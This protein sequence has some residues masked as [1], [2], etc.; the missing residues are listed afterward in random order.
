MRQMSDKVR[1]GIIGFGGMGEAHA[2]YI[3]KDGVPH[4]VLTAVCDPLPG[5]LARARELFGDSV[6]GFAKAEDLFAA[7]LVDG[8]LIA[9]PHYV[10]PDLAIQAFSHGMHVL[11]EKPAGVYTKQ[12]RLM[13]E[14]AAKSGKVFG[15]MFNQRTVPIH[16]KL[17]DLV[18]SG[19]LGDLKRIQWTVTSWY[20]TQAYYDSGGWRA[21]W[22]GE[23]GGVLIN[24]CPHQL[25]LYQWTFGLPKRVRAFCAF[26]KYH[27]I[28]VEDDVTAY[29][30]Y[31]NGVTAT[32]IATTGEAPGTNRLEVAADWGK[33]VM[34]DNKLS[35]WR[36]RMSERQF[37][38]EST[39][40]F[41]S[42]ESWKCEIPV[43]GPEGG[44]AAITSNWVQAIREGTALIAPGEEG[45]KSLELSNAMFLSTW[46]DRT[47]EL[48]VDEDLFE[49]HLREKI[50]TST[51]KK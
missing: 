6:R 3:A 29:L 32:F 20:R 28:E 40:Q 51:F 16:I 11:I 12:V 25:D 27:R 37:N 4:G 41:G 18:T 17:R 48:P 39:R 50:R 43:A 34:E 1:I 2:R 8:V 47:I 44:H 7:K 19:E 31:P 21:T 30:E 10:H 22:A 5:R 38:R 36:N 14:A 24:Q 46:E 9:T 13:N 35:F 49:R 45:I 23:G 33:L 26:G 42:L 15:I